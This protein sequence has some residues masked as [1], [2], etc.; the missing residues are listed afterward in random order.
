[1]NGIRKATG[2]TN[3][4]SIGRNT[5][6]N[7]T[8]AGSSFLWITAALMI[9]VGVVFQVGEL[10]LSHIRLDNLWLVSVVAS[11]LWNLIATRLG[12]PTV[13][14]VLRYWPL[15]LVGLGF[16]IMLA[17]QENRL[18]RATPVVRK[19]ARYGL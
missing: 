19:G 11:D 16:S 2:V 3:M 4:A 14:Q 9:L 10:G 17:T 8:M 6:I 12:G 13:T 5:A 1:M 15:I 18:K 7:T